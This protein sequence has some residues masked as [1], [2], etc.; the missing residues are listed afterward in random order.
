M[1]I[2]GHPRFAGGHDTLPIAKATTSSDS[3]D[4]FAALYRLLASSNVRI[5]MAGDT[6]DFE[7]YREK[8]GGGGAARVMH[9]FVN[10]GGGAYLSI[11]TALDF[12]EHAARGRL[13]ILSEDRQPSR[14]DGGRDA[15]MEAAVLVWI[16]WFN[17]W[18]FSVEA[19]P[20]CSI[21]TMRPSSRAS[22]RCESERSKKRVV[23][24]L[25]GVE[26][27]CAGETCKPVSALFPAGA[28]PDDPVEFIVL[29]NGQ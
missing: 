2:V 11:G 28:R 24:V 22:W 19:C 1:A 14:Q 29:M 3:A 7:Y 5:A 25:N 26:A 4:N 27:R 9:H 8:I 20:A 17:G 13:G 6:H 12:P 21:S 15:A 18:P 23:F 10:G 16:K